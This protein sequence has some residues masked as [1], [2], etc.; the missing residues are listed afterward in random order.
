MCN[1]IAT[2]RKGNLR[3]VLKYRISIEEAK[4]FMR[5]CDWFYIDHLGRTYDL[6]IKTI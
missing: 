3:K 5:A 4:A 2:T 6:T 1:V